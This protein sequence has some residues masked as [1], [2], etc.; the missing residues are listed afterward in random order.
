MLDVTS[1]QACSHGGR[2]RV[3]TALPARNY[4]FICDECS[5]R[6]VA[7]CGWIFVEAS[8]ED[9]WMNVPRTSEGYGVVQSRT[10]LLRG[11]LT[12]FDPG[13]EISENASA[14]RVLES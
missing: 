11:R 2:V 13:I 1:S 9:G 10:L 12:G 5:S 6:I 7:L 8:L 4:I 14:D 3:C